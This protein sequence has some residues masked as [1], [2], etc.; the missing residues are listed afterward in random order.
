[1]AERHH[2]G[3]VVLHGFVNGLGLTKPAFVF[4]RFVAVQM[5]FARAKAHNF[6]GGCDFEPLG[7]GL[8][9]FC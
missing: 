3:N 4:R 2:I 9:S 8:L 5:T 6:A 1:M 7:G